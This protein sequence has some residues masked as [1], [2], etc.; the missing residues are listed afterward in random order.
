MASSACS[1]S[2]F[3]SSMSSMPAEMRIRVSV[4][5]MAAP[6]F[7]RHRGMRHRR[8]M[9]DERLDAA[10]ALGERH[11]LEAV[12]HARAPPR[13]R[14]PRT[15]ACR[16][17]RAASAGARARAA[18]VREAR[19]VDA[20]D[21]RVRLEELAPAP[22]RWPSA[23]PSAAAASWCR[24]APARSRTGSGSRRAEFWMNFSHS[25]SSSRVAITTPPIESLWPLRYFVVLC[26]TRSAPSSSGRCR[27]GLAN[28]LSTATSAPWRC[29]S[30]RRPRCP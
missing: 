15:T 29:A 19:V 13:R 24:A 28:V 1:R 9:T 2:S 10:Q 6:P 25:M 11:Q 23:A 5:P 22:G 8:R 30:S 17:S 7:G 20:C 3:R 16:R 21:L 27:Q 18:D 4:R 12:E 14:P 26:T